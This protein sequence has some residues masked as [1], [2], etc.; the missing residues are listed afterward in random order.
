MCPFD[1]SFC[2]WLEG[3]GIVNRFNNTSWVAVVAPAGHPKSVR[4][5]CVIEVF[6]GVFCVVMV[7]FMDF[8]V[9]VAAFVLGLN[10]FWSFFS[11]YQV[12]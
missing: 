3:R 5:R 11:P 6:C 4:N 7:F 10:Q 12:S 9:V 1:N 8:S 2:G